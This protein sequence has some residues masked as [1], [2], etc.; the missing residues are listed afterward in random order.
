MA[1]QQ[2]AMAIGPVGTRGRNR[3]A[4]VLSVFH[5][6]KWYFKSIDCFRGCA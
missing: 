5:L 4:S 2:R 3:S 1:E 6:V